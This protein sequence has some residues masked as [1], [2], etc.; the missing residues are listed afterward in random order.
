MNLSLRRADQRRFSIELDD[1]QTRQ[2]PRCR[3]TIERTI[4]SPRPALPLSRARA[5]RLAPQPAT[6]AEPVESGEHHV[7][8]DQ[9]RP[10]RFGFRQSVEPG[11]SRQDVEPFVA[12]T[13]AEVVDDAVFIVD[14][15]DPPHGPSL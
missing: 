14:D 5:A 6:A 11:R 4:A 12:K 13:E 15:Q 3:P 2:T 9:I 7:K 8:D 10:L 1:S